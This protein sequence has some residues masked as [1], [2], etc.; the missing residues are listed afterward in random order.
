MS[1]ISNIIAGHINE[2]TGTNNNLAESRLNICHEC[3]LFKNV[4]GG[5]C[6]PKLWLNPYTGELS[7]SEK[8]GFKNGC[9]CRLQAKTTLEDEECPVGKW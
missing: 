5:I 9:G 4:F 1:S 7:L 6:N 2:L 3:P 8:E